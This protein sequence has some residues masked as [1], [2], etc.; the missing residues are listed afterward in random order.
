MLRLI[1]FIRDKILNGDISTP[2]VKSKDQLADMFI[3]VLKSIRLYLLQV[4]FI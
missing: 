1:D 3:K 2:F 4:E